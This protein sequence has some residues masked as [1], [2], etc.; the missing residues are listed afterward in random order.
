VKLAALPV[1]ALGSGQTRRHA[2]RPGTPCVAIVSG[3]RIVCIAF[4]APK[5]LRGATL[6]RVAFHALQDRLASPM[7]ETVH[8][9]TREAPGDTALAFAAAADEVS[10]W[11]SEAKAAGWQPAVLLPDWLALP[12]RA[13]LWSLHAAG[14]MVIAR[15]GRLAGFTAETPLATAILSRRLA[16]AAPRAVLLPGDASATAALR[17][18]FADKSIPLHMDPASPGAQRFAAQE[19]AAS[20]GRHATSPLAAMATAA[21][22]WAAPAAL[23]FVAFAAWS[24]TVV[25]DIR[26]DLAV[27]ESHAAQATDAFRDIHGNG[28]PVVDMRLQT[29]RRLDALRAGHDESTVDHAFGPLL[30][31]AEEGLSSVRVHSIGW[32]E[33]TGLSAEISVGDF[34]ALEVLVARLR[35][36]GLDVDIARADARGGAGVDAALTLAFTG[37]TP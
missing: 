34:A 33:R 10:A 26:R 11:L 18:Q 36:A 37:G 20:L 6:E 7:T 12:W 24:T 16:E 31:A 9:A 21:R 2:P 17:D 5:R 25:L 14:D 15:T 8:V 35:D 4:P 22:P 1:I 23:A 19:A 29:A 27:A 28:V 30:A 3:T 32:R 13:G